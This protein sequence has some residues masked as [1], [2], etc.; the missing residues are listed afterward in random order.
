MFRHVKFLVDRFHYSGHKCCRLFSM[1]LYP[2]LGRINSSILESINSF[3]QSYRP[4]LSQMS[5]YNF[6]HYLE[7][8]FTVRNQ[9][10]KDKFETAANWAF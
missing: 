4:Q 9:S 7:Y 10:V 8:I 2:H 5:Q 1:D 6:M 3:V